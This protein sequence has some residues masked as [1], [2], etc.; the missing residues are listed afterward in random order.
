MLTATGSN[1]YT[2]PTAINQ[3]AMIVNGSLASPVTVNSGGVLSGTGSVGSVTVNAGGQ[4][5]RRAM[6]RAR[7]TSPA[8]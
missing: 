6:R 7:C 8:R 1:T 5:L 3:G 4:A 2:G